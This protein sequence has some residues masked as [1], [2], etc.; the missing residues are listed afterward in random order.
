MANW[1]S[2]S[3]LKNKSM[4]GKWSFWQTVLGQVDV[5]VCDPL[6]CSTPD[7]PVPHHLP[8]FAQVHVHCIAL[9]MPPCHLILWCPLLLLP[10]VFPRTFPMSHL[11]TSNEQNTG[12]SALASVLPANIQGLPPLKLTGL[13]SLLSRNSQEPSPAL[14]FKGI[15]SV[16]FSLLHSSALTTTC[17]H[18]EDHSFNYMDLCWQCLCFSTH[19]LGLSSL[20]CQKSIFFWFHGYSHRLQSFWSPR[21]G[22]LPLLPSFPKMEWS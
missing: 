10:S 14:Q 13:I 5:V 18:W 4:G 16:V 22:N 15:N 1:F 12:A 21:R 2:T 3:I 9:V 17:D 20:S 11:F 6:D 7:L 19:C 8:E